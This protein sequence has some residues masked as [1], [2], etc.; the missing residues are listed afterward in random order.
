MTKR[1]ATPLKILV[2]DDNPLLQRAMKDMLGLWGVGIISTVGNG[3]EAM[4]LLR[5]DRFD[6]LVTDWV[7]EPVGGQQL[8]EWV[9]KSPA[10]QR[11]DLPI[12]VLTA[13]ADLSTVRAAWDSGADSV[14]AKPVAA[15]TLAKRIE[16]VLNRREAVV[17]PFPSAKRPPAGAGEAKA[18]D[19]A[20]VPQESEALPGVAATP[21]LPSPTAPRTAAYLRSSDHKRVRLLLALD[22][23]EAAIERPDP[24]APRLRRAVADLQSATA[25]D[26]TASSIVS[27][28]ATCVTWVDPDTDGYSDALHAHAAALR[29][30]AGDEGG[31]Q[32]AAVVLSLVRTLRAT[33]RTLATRGQV[34]LGGWPERP[35]GQNGAPSPESPLPPA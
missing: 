33:V 6:L 4:E 1:A 19:D 10:S 24:L 30:F 8:I 22:R 21:R 17:K 28:L 12:I 15:A 11:T 31:P 9:R 20:G 27:S 26:H 35:G 23:L 2:V 7:M 13:N 16:A 5:R 34:D 18:A 14:L 3:Q 32:S 29:W 25:G